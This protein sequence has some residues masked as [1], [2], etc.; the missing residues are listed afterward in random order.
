M[1]KFLFSLG[2]AAAGMLLAGCQL[3]FSECVP[4]EGDALIDEANAP[5]AEK[6]KEGYEKRL[7]FRC[8]LE[9]KPAEEA[10][11]FLSSHS[12]SQY[13]EDVKRD[14]LLTVKNTL[15]EQLSGMRDFNLVGQADSLSGDLAPQVS[16][17][18]VKK[19]NYWMTYSITGLDF[20]EEV[21]TYYEDNQKRRETRYYGRAKV[22]I[23]LYDPSGNQLYIFQARGRS[24][25]YQTRQDPELL[26]Q[27]V[28][29][30]VAAAL[31]KYSVATAPPLYVIKTIGNG[32]FAQIAGGT[33]YGITA[34]SRIRFY[35]HHVREIG[36][37]RRPRMDEIY[38]GEGIV[39]RGNAP[40][41][42][43]SAWVYIG[44]FRDPEKQPQRTVFEW[45][46]AKLVHSQED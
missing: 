13:R 7:Q 28:G 27:A 35:R 18:A 38:V 14:L 34:G 16:S 12:F 39:G 15:A 44:D 46:S 3:N 19:V 31:Y 41:G 5:F 4:M 43:D 32:S 40:V 42:E 8:D 24:D 25:D 2:A 9:L 33:A 23:G 30:A 11:I 36:K 37:T 45:T 1:N 17:E 26:K 20:K 29:K 10:N 6:A 21:Y 22:Q